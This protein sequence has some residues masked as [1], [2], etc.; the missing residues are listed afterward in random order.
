M[1]T[2]SCLHDALLNCRSWRMNFRW[3]VLNTWKSRRGSRSKSLHEGEM[4]RNLRAFQGHCFCFSWDNISSWAWEITET[5]WTE[6]RAERSIKPL[7]SNVKRGT[8]SKNESMS[9]Q[10]LSRLSGRSYLRA[11]IWSAA[12]SISCQT[13]TRR[14]F[15][16][17][18]T[19]PHL[20]LCLYFKLYFSLLW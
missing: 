11:I 6:C 16:T 19:E 15:K 17:V 7:N 8:F 10:Q 3:P 2:L 20:W 9:L 1:Q 14:S 12:E 4:F 13:T 18:F 5:N